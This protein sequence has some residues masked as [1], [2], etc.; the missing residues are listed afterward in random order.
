LHTCL[1]LFL[2]SVTSSSDCGR[3]RGSAGKCPAEDGGQFEIVPAKKQAQLQQTLVTND[4]TGLSMAEYWQQL[5]NGAGEA[6]PGNESSA[7]A[8]CNGGHESAA[9][10]GSCNRHSNNNYVNFN[11]FIMQHNLGG[12]APSNATSTMQHPVGSSYTNFSLGGGGG[13]F[14]LNPPVASASTSHFANVSHQ[15]PNVCFDILELR[16]SPNES[17]NKSQ[18]SFTRRP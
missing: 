3:S 17:T 8:D 12:G 16:F 18:N 4:S 10:G 11:Q 6:G 14:G 1:E 9:V 15:S 2:G 5:T 13:A 7:M